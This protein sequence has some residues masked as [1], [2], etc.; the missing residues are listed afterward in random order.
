MN[1]EKLLGIGKLLKSK[2][3]ELGL[4]LQEVEQQTLI[5][6]KYLVALEE[7]RWEDLPGHSYIYGYIKIY[8]RILNCDPKV[9]KE[10]FQ[11][12]MPNPPKTEAPKNSS[13]AFT[14]VNASIFKKILY[15]LIITAAVFTTLYVSIEVRK[16]GII[17]DSTP[18]IIVTTSNPEGS[19]LVTLGTEPT[20]LVQDITPSPSPPYA[21][22][23][24]LRPEDVAYLDMTSTDNRKIFSGVLVPQK[25]YSFRSNSPLILSFLNG[26]KVK[27][28]HNGTDAGYLA[29]NDQRT[30]RTFRP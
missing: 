29:D 2:R 5:N 23:V 1:D 15:F 7:E 21:L 4:S 13:R 22:Q 17:A 25:E 9:L 24:V 10:Q 26:S 14:P 12:S 19:P 20:P 6:R 3:E 28:I 18:L 16:D 27:V 8:G 11:H 30:E